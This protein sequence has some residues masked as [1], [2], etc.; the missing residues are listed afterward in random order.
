MDAPITVKQIE[1]KLGKLRTRLVDTQHRIGRLERVAEYYGREEHITALTKKAAS[2][3]W[4][5]GVLKT[6][7]VEIK[8]EANTPC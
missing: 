8:G 4:E 3:E 7:M 2:I 1:N 5:I 6:K